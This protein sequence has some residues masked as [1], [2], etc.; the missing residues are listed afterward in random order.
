MEYPNPTVVLRSGEAVVIIRGGGNEPKYA[1]TLA[2]LFMVSVWGLIVPFNA[3]L[4]PV[5]VLPEFA[6]AVIVTGVPA[7]YQPLFGLIVPPKE[8]VVVRK[9]CVVKFAV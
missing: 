2:A 9:Y 3:P 1:V 6:L 8:P 5:K 4:K 7:V